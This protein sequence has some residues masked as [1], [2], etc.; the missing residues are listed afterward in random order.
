MYLRDHDIFIFSLGAHRHVAGACMCAAQ[1]SRRGLD[2]EHQGN[3][4]LTFLISK[5]QGA[6]DEKRRVCVT[7]I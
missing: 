2:V 4:M 1:G 3:V 7:H 6:S 5:L